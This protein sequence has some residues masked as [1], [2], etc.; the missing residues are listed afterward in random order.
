MILAGDRIVET[1]RYGG[2]FMQ[3]SRHR[4]VTDHLRRAFRASVLDDTV[5]DVRLRNSRRS[6]LTCS[7]VIPVKSAKNMLLARSARC[8]TAAMICSFSD[9]FMIPSVFVY[10]IP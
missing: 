8:F 3:M 10:L 9:R 4:I 6:S 5:F 2:G 7:T 1:E